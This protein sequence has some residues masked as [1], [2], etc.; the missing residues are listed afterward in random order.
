MANRRRTTAADEP[1][2]DETVTLT[3]QQ[4]AL[5]QALNQQREGFRRETEEREEQM[6]MEME[7]MRRE[8]EQTRREAEQTRREAEQLR[9]D[10]IGN[11]PVRQQLEEMR[12]EAREREERQRQ[13]MERQAERHRQEAAAMQRELN[14]QRRPER[15]QGRPQEAPQEVRRDDIRELA[16]VLRPNQQKI[17]APTFNGKKDVRKFLAVFDEVRRNNRWNEEQAS[18]NLRLSLDD[19]ISGSVQG[20]TYN[21]IRDFLLSRYELTRDEA[22]RE[23]KIAR[24]KKGESIYEFGDHVLQ[25]VK[26]A[27]PNTA[28][29]VQE[30]TA[31]AEL[32]D[33]LGEW[34]LRREFRNQPPAN[35]TEA[36]RRINEYNSDRGERSAIK[37]VDFNL[38]EDE[39]ITRIKQELNQ[40]TDKING[41]ES[42]V[43]S[44]ETSMNVKLNTIIEAVKKEP[45]QQTTPT[46]QPR[47]LGGNRAQESRVCFYCNIPGHLMRECRKRE[48]DN[49]MA[50]QGSRYPNQRP[51]HGQN[52]PQ[53]QD[54]R[55]GQGQ[56]SGNFRGPVA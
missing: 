47:Y 18:L 46:N 41:V 20:D 48:A 10:T 14:E 26:L 15:N 44:L 53:G 3:P 52:Q 24:P 28:E 55:Q 32:I 40:V 30:E 21:E 27:H 51:Q 6:R 42:K 33:S 29:E 35:Y 9:M 1:T 8:A 16:D 11:E 4:R 12:Q 54:A 56:Q 45:T 17:K 39:Q 36:L 5:Q 13:E 31:V 19:T 34:V 37:R 23:L 7:E 22:R 43:T 38:T 25:M 49:R 2:T 50:N